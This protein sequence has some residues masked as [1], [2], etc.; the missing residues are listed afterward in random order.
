[1]LNVAPVLDCTMRRLHLNAKHFQGVSINLESPQK[2]VKCII[3]LKNNIQKRNQQCIPTPFPGIKLI[4][5]QINVHERHVA[6][7]CERGNV[8]DTALTQTLLPQ[9][10]KKCAILKIKKTVKAV[11]K[12]KLNIKWLSP[13]TTLTFPTNKL[14][15]YPR[16]SRDCQQLDDQHNYRENKV[17]AQSP[18]RN[19][20]AR[21]PC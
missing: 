18:R 8:E 6:P 3:A 7:Q 2:A 19:L 20:V 10:S 13:L 4:N 11:S 21:S 12:V 9:R 14:Y 1:M 16:Q 5:I 17:V 15:T